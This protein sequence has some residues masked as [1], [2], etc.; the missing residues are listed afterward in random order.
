MVV[1][2]S[3]PS[4]V[5]QAPEEESCHLV[6]LQMT[7]CRFS[8]IHEMY[9]PTFAVCVW[10]GKKPKKMIVDSSKLSSVFEVSSI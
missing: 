5:F 7:K 10:W 9:K 2:A 3:S 6:H 1:A 8:H 4:L